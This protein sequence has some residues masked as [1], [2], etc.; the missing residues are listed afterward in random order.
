VDFDRLARGH[1][2]IDIAVQELNF[3][4]WEVNLEVVMLYAKNPAAQWAF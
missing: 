4:G 1:D 2:T 3:I